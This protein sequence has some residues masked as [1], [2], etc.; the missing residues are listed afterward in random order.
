MGERVDGTFL[1]FSSGAG[2]GTDALG[3]PLTIKAADSTGN[4]GS[5]IEFF[6]AKQSQG[7]G[8]TVR[9]AAKAGAFNEDGNF[10]AENNVVVTGTVTSATG[11]AFGN[12]TLANGSIT[13][14]SGAISFDNE[15]LSTTGTL[16][17]GNLSVTGTGA[18]SSTISAATGSAIGTLTLADGSITDSSGTISFDD[19]N[20]TTTGTLGCGNLTVTGDLTVNGTTTTVNTTNTTVTDSLLELANGTTGTPSN[21][22][23]IVIERG[24]SANAFIGWDE[25]EDKF[26]VATGNF[27]GSVSGNLNDESR[28]QNAANFECNVLTAATGSTVGTLTLANGSITD[29][30][31][32]ISFV[33]ENLSTTGTLGCGVLTAATGSS[34]GTLTLANGSITDSSGAI[35]FV[36]ENLSTTGTLASGNLSVTGTGAFSSTI[37]AATGSTVGTLTLADGTIT[38]SSGAISFDNENLTT[39]GT[40]SFGTLTDSSVSIANFVNESAGI[41][42]NINDTTV[43]TCAAVDDYTI[44]N[45]N[46]SKIDK[47]TDNYLFIG[48]TAGNLDVSSAGE[49]ENNTSIGINALNN[50]TTGSSNTCIGKEAGSTLTAGIQNTFIGSTAGK[51]IGGANL[52]GNNNVCIGFNSQPSAANASNEITLGNSSTSELRCADTAIAS[53]SDERDKKDV[54]DLP[55]GLD[56]IDTL[57]PVQFTW[58]RRVLTP[59]DENHPK[60]GKKRA[61]FLAQDFQRAMP[62]NENEILDLVYE[63]SPERIEAKYG[64]LIPMLTQAI[65][66]LKAQNEALMA[67]VEALENKN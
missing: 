27:N 8:T 59:D 39:T 37:S 30:S 6:V 56:F 7:A 26:I 58:D 66:D 60:N 16:A 51:S 29:S 65:K 22:A 17:S 41:T 18:F 2:S 12:L 48:T 15:N 23:G 9:Q 38:D 32:A 47:D 28:T 45:K 10:V 11:S 62:N 3:G 20:L 5:K 35:S 43:P 36:N 52:T 50:I 21:D 24:D 13:D 53:L 33:N 46:N 34:V 44:F 57:R 49:G 31:G 40:I 54:I 42:N 4:G 19:E 67:R 63:C 1:T 55:W 14:S 61:G 25:S 64:N